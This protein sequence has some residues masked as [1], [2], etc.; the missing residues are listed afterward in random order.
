MS[1]YK[2]EGI[3]DDINNKAK[4][5]AKYVKENA[6]QASAGTLG[7]LGGGALG[8]L[9]SG[10]LWKNPSKVQR[11]LTMLVGAG[12]GTGT[13]L[14]TIGAIKEYQK[15][16]QQNLISATSDLSNVPASIMGYR[17]SKQKWKT[18]NPLAKA[19][20]GGTDTG[21]FLTDTLGAGVNTLKRSLPGSQS[22]AGQWLASIGGGILGQQMARRPVLQKLRQQVRSSNM[23]QDL[24]DKVKAYRKLD[25]SAIKQ[26]QSIKKRLSSGGIGYQQALNLVDP[27]KHSNNDVSNILKNLNPNIKNKDL[28]IG[29]KGR[30]K[31]GGAGLL[32]ALAF[33]LLTNT[34]TGANKSYDEYLKEVQGN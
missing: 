11:L 6:P 21:G 25:S 1:L 31:T 29:I 16:P 34:L 28:K 14:T 32:G 8:Y 26:I 33:G 23:L 13:G 17:P 4:D 3:L 12:I 5:F 9:S 20:Y 15:S 24:T 19:L 18:L 10:L 30:L 27:S 7:A 22:S 2:K